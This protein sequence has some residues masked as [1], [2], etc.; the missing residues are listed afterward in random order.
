MYVCR[1]REIY[2]FHENQLKEMQRWCLWALKVNQRLPLIGEVL[3]HSN[4][5]HQKDKRSGKPQNKGQQVNTRNMFQFRWK[6]KR[7][8]WSGLVTPVQDRQQTVGMVVTSYDRSL[9]TISYQQ[10]V[11]SMQI[12]E[13]KY[14]VSITFWKRREAKAW[15]RLA[16]STNCKKRWK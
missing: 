16:S 2:T 12:A 4:K 5:K 10:C 9:Q 3:S 7:T 15:C 6:N 1:F 13:P 14:K 8:V 11:E